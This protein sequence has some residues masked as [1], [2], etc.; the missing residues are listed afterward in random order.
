MRVIDA[1]SDERSRERVESATS[2]ATPVNAGQ[3]WLDCLVEELAPTCDRCEP[4]VTRRYY[5]SC[6]IL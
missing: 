5:E 6:T 1:G 4:S 2:G 3:P